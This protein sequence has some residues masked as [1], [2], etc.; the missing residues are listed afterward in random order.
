[1]TDFDQ[2]RIARWIRDAFTI[3]CVRHAGSSPT[4]R[5]L[6]LGFEAILI[7]LGTSPLHLAASTLP[8]PGRAAAASLADLRRIIEALDRCRVIFQRYE[9]ML[10]PTQ[11]KVHALVETTRSY[12]MEELRARQLRLLARPE[13]PVLY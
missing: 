7:Q 1:M 11:C 13:M 4:E 8:P 2:Q 5:S 3:L 6:R 10:S 9:S 12:A